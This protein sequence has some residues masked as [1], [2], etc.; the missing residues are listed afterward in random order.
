MRISPVKEWESREKVI[1][2]K[3]FLYDIA[4]ACIFDSV[5]LRVNRKAFYIFD[6][7][8][9]ES[10]ITSYDRFGDEENKKRA[11]RNAGQLQGFQGLV[12]IT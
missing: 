9:G 7:G 6:A 4:S 1:S 10:V 2:Q 8:V 11:R 3:R 5:S 12:I